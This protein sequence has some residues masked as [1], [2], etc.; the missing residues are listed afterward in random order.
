MRFVVLERDSLV[1]EARVQVY[2]CPHTVAACHRIRGLLPG[3]AL[4]GLQPG[5]PEEWLRDV[6]APVEKLGRMLI[7]EDAIRALQRTPWPSC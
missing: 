4:E 1:Q 5:T 6:N 2:G 3:Q 7:I